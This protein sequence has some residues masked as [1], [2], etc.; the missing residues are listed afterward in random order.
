MESELWIRRGEGTGL[1]LGSWL[2]AAVPW[3]IEFFQPLSWG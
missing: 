3:L 2:W 1:A